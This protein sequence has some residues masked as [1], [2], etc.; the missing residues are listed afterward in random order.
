[1]GC[2]IFQYGKFC[3]LS[4]SFW[5]KNHSQKFYSGLLLEDSGGTPYSGSEPWGLHTLGYFSSKPSNPHSLGWLIQWYHPREESWTQ[6]STHKGA[7]PHFSPSGHSLTIYHIYG[8]T[9]CPSK[10]WDSSWGPVCRLSFQE[11]SLVGRS[12]LLASMAFL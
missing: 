8:S 11:C 10:L 1:M 6:T 9:R 12:L 4:T 3:N 7:S 2:L 5:H